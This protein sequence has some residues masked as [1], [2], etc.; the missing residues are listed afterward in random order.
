MKPAGIVLWIAAV[1]A[2]TWAFA[3]GDD[4]L[5]DLGDG[6][7]MRADGTVVGAWDLPGCELA[8]DAFDAPD[9]V[10]PSADTSEAIWQVRFDRGW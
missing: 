10:V 3:A 8:D 7:V 9:V 6:L 2:T 4:G 1:L 5:I